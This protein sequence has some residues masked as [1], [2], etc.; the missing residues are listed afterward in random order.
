MI[1]MQ[2]NIKFHNITTARRLAPAKTSLRLTARVIQEKFYIYSILTGCRP[3]IFLVSKKK[4]KTG[5]FA[6][7]CR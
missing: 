4:S 2:Y 7:E 6:M 3:C 5:V 1:R